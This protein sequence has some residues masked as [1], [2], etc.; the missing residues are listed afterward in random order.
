MTFDM[1]WLLLSLLLSGVGMVL[2]MY[3]KR[4]D[5]APHLL[6][7]AIFCVYPYFVSNLLLLAGI[8][9]ALSIGL[10]VAVRMQG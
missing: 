2:L 9:V 3:G 1:N 10:W 7:G 8:A 6:V 5:S 4:M